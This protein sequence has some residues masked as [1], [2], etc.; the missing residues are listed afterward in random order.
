MSGSTLPEHPSLDYL[1]KLAKERLRDLR[2]TDPAARLAAAQLDIAREH[3]FPSWRALKAE[4]DRRQATPAEAFFAACRAGDVPALRGL[5][6]QDPGL[7]DARDA[8]GSTG[9]HQ[10]IHHVEAVRLL[11]ERGADPNA[12]DVGDNAY[13][14]HFASAHGLLDTMR[15]L[16][17]AG[18][19]VHG[20]GDLH[21][22]DVIGWAAGQGRQE[23]R[24]AVAL[25]VERGAR[26]H[27]FSAIAMGDADLVRRVVRENP[28][29][30]SRRRSRF[31]HRQTAL[32][33]ALA[34]PVGLGPKAVQHDMVE[35][36]IQLGAD[37]EAKDDLGRTPL[38]VAMLSADLRAT[39]LL[40]AAGATAPQRVSAPD[41]PGGLAA[42]GA[43]ILKQV[44]SVV[45]KDM[46]AT[47]AWYR[48]IGFTLRGRHPAEG[49][50]DWASLTY[51]KTEIM[52]S[53]YGD[54]VSLWLYTDRIDDLYQLFKARQIAAVQ[55]A[56]DGGPEP[57]IRFEE[58]LYAPFY[59][60]R[61]FSIR[62][63]GGLG[64]IF[65]QE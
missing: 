36:L 15:I 51:G 2:R 28:Q 14:L 17:D 22:S 64:L 23:Q 31:E 20:V 40:T 42:L 9:L 62:D 25:L 10:A 29:A 6:D 4:L 27:I 26:H 3:G 11:L 56:L 45:V 32:H 33:F 50:M 53:P 16:L 57:D 7:A 37:L 35:L 12:R 52:L 59:G 65:Y 39:R 61:Q 60:G 58:D 21:D 54:P 46:G 41:I 43:S 8:E 24:D 49:E 19:D 48:S 47:V 13:P 34:A 18:G 30:L 63:P 55:A 38:E 1:K 5:L 44:P